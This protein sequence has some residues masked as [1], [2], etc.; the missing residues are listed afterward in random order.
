MTDDADT[1][2]SALV[3]AG[4][5]TLVFLGFWM[6][7]AGVKPV[8]LAVGAIT[9]ALAAWASL[10][11]LSPGHFRIR[12]LAVCAYALRFMVGSVKAGLDVAWRALH[13]AVP[14]RPGFVVYDTRLPA[15]PLRNTFCTVTSL[16]PGTLPC[17]FEGENGIV[18]HCLDMDQPVAEQLALEEVL[19]AEALGGRGGRRDD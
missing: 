12:L 2:R 4:I 14:L 5:R 6:A 15:G 17:G 10:R 19:I 16:L 7:L 11:F 3:S 18:V 1:S 8:D 9:A 13:P